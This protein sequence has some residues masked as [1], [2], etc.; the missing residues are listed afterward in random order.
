MNNW[1]KLQSEALG[2]HG[3]VTLAK[4]REL[5]IFT[6]EIYRW[7]RNDRL[8]KVGRGVYRL[9]AYPSQGFV[10]DMAAL[11]ALCGE[12]AY[13]FGESVL[14]LYDLCPTRSYVAVV[15]IPRRFRKN[16]VPHGVKIV[17]APPSYKYVFHQGLPC[18]RPM[19]AI[20]SCVGI[21]EPERILQA[22]DEAEDKGYLLPAEADAL[23]KEIGNGK[24]T[25]Q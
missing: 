14:A 9:T 8:M 24:A 25:A 20:R 13:L 2:S 22:I 5:G 23:R 12:G 4:A 11:L 6:T 15:A 1:E 3:I 19:D 16:D 21:L 7:C 18:Q 10:S 17:K